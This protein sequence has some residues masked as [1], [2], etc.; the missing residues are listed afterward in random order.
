[1]KVLGLFPHAVLASIAKATFDAPL[2]WSFI[3]YN[4]CYYICRS[5]R[6]FDPDCHRK[7][8]V[9]MGLRGE[10]APSCIQDRLPVGGKGAAV[11]LSD[12]TYHK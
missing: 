9:G 4:G 8:I 3:A 1:M 6:V 11:A 12:I 10:W 5:R 7:I 2:A